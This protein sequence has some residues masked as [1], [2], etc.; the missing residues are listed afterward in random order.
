MLV[1][2]GRLC[3]RLGR[4]TYSP[5]R[6]G[7]VRIR[8]GRGQGILHGS[9]L[10]PTLH[11]LASLPENNSRLPALGQVFR[12]ALRCGGRVPEKISNELAPDTLPPAAAWTR[13]VNKTRP[14]SSVS[15]C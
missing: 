11:I 3:F 6:F 8:S 15:C 13:V 5:G 9:D 7:L 2:H 14:D 12:L 4:T 10:F 1:L